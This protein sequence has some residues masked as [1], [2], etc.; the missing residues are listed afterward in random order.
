MDLIKRGSKT[1]KQG[2]EN[3]KD[4]AQKFNNW[5]KDSD[6]QDWLKIMEYKLEDLDHVEAIVLPN[7]YKA[8]IQIKVTIYL[9][10]ALSAE[11][12]SIKLVSNPQG[13]NQVDKR[14]V[15]TYQELWEI[16]TDVTKLLKYYTGELAPYKNDTRDNRRMF[17]D[18]FTK[19]EQEVVLG[20]F[21]RNKIL[22]LT[23]IIKGRGRLSADWMMVALK[24]LTGTEWVLT[25]ISVALNTFGLG[26]VRI[27][28]KGNLKLGQVGI[29]RKGGDGGRKTAQ[30]LQFKVNPAILIALS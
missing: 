13:F 18:E 29:Q 16:P 27:T 7:H 9:K 10:Q 22:I 30:M 11:N 3:E 4:I 1:A 8:D 20:F 17:L 2:F 26:D 19:D 14:W 24:K 15:D 23:D 12:I 5:K 25:P 21:D 28:E 6:A